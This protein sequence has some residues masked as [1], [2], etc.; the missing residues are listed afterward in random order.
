MFEDSDIPGPISGTTSSRKN[1]DDGESSDA[2]EQVKEANR[3]IRLID[4]LAGYGIKLLRNSRRPNW[5]VNIR[6]PLPTHKGANERTPSFGYC[7]LTDHF[8]CLGCG[9][10][11]RGVEFLSLKDGLP[12]YVV[13]KTILDHYGNTPSIESIDEY[14]DDLSGV[15]FEFSSWLNKFLQENKANADLLAKTDKLLWWIDL[16]LV[17]KSTIHKAVSKD[18]KYR[19]DKTKELLI[20]ELSNSG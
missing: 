8:T 9:Q 1:S 12:R 11:G 6:C 10:S 17:K 19:L 5:S 13:A 3:K 4:I 16:Y 2:I 18:L 14:K 20:N 15:L 7:Y